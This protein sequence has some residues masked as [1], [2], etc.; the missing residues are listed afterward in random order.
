[1]R[2]TSDWPELEPSAHEVPGMAQR[3]Y[4]GPGIVVPVGARRAT[5]ARGDWETWRSMRG[6]FSNVVIFVQ[7][8]Y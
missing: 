2:R 1:M 8:G 3:A 6:V 5:T 4:R 7:I